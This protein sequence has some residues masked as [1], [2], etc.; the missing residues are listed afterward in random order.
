MT[1]PFRKL[2]SPSGIDLYP[3]PP[4]AVRLSRRAGVL[5]LVVV[6][7]VVALI[8]Y[9]VIT[10]RQRSVELVQLDGSKSVTAAT[11]VGKTIA[12]EV[13]A[14][15][16]AGTAEQSIQSPEGEESADEDWEPNLSHT[17]PA[18]RPPAQPVSAQ[19]VVTAPTA[20]SLSP[21]E[22]RRLAAYRLEFQAID[23][24]T[25]TAGGTGIG[26]SVET[27]PIATGTAAAGAP[28]SLVDL[29]RNAMGRSSATTNP[30]K[31]LPPSDG[32]PS[33]QGEDDGRDL[34]DARERFLERARQNTEDEVLPATRRS[35]L[36]R[37]EIKAGWDIPA[38]LEHA[39]NSDLPGEVRALVRENVYD[40]ATGRYLLIPQGSR[41]VGIYDSRIAYG[42]D[43][44]M[45]V[46]NRIIF[47]D[48][49]SI[50]LEGMASQDA[51][52]QSGMRHKVDNHYRR[53]LGFAALTSVFSAAFQ[54]S[55]SP[56]GGILAY[57][58]PGE[59]AGSAVG[60]ELSQFGA[61]VTRRNLNVQPTIRIPVGN[62]FNVRVNRDLVF[63]ASI[64]SKYSHLIFPVPSSG[65]REEAVP[66]P[67][68]R[69]H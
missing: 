23:A 69:T 34:Q 8:G 47:P 35:P 7:G 57:P 12:A 54:L 63:P 67:E 58:S 32:Q 37:Y 18:W 60:R 66:P 48:G 17:P 31:A 6:C 62:R 44:M 26:T 29:V 55:Q 49:S 27:S 56:R 42:Q 5:A 64:L 15:S 3:A 1:N 25:A 4:A 40:T 45:V 19:A 38:V 22:A 20:Q 24:P 50:R 21:A 52:G 51:S 16:L 68:S 65:T 11:E 9:G 39:L 2:E 43:G 61:Q 46:W 33:E 28:G 30:L 14:K 13:P 36:S 10:R 59:M 41:L 53:L